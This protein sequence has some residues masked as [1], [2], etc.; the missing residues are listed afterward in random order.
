MI[1]RPVEPTPWLVLPDG[2]GVYDNND[3][4]FTLVMNHELAS[5]SGAIRAHGATGSFISRYVIDKS[6]MEVLGGSDLIQQ[7]FG[8]NAVTGSSDPAPSVVAFNRFCSGD[9]AASSAY[10][11]N[12]LGSSARIFLTGEEGGQ[13][14]AVAT[15]VTGP[16]AETATSWARSIRRRTAPRSSA[17][18]AGRTSWPIHSRR[19]RPS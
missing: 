14:R 9:L 7:V 17:W 6:T 19:R 18:A 11:Y 3:G 13:G 8:W 15:I 1:R 16:E 2:L 5:G 4:T 12:G 10:L